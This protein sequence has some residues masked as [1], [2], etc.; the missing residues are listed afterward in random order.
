MDDKENLDEFR[1][2]FSLFDKKGDNRIERAQIGEV[3]RALGLNPTVSEVK[4]SILDIPD[5]RVSFE[6]FLPIYHSMRKKIDAGSHEEFSEGLRV[7]DREGNGFISA[8]E[9]RHVLTSLGEKLTD[10]EVNELIN[11]IEDSQGQVQ[12]EEFVKMVMA[13]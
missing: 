13:N 5:E 2:T 10:D 9:L 4:K 12:Y 7:F 11:T 1:D 6:Q 3:A 8:A